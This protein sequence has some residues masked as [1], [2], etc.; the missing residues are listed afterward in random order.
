M[1]NIF[2]YTVK[3]SKIYVLIYLQKWIYKSMICVL[4]IYILLL[5]W[6]NCWILLV[7]MIPF[8]YANLFQHVLKTDNSFA[9]N[10]IFFSLYALYTC[11][12]IEFNVM[13]TVGMTPIL[14]LA[15]LIKI[16]I[17]ICIKIK[18][19]SLSVL[20]NNFPRSVVPIA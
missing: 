12:Y 4:E 2:F 20:C 9:F 14:M 1:K 15:F 5:Y 8:T 10:V 6:I 7:R 19:I 16:C 3:N 17:C 13:L 11:M 18:I